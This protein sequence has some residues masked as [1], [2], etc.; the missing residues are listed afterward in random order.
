MCKQEPLTMRIKDCIIIIIII[1][2]S[3]VVY[4]YI[5]PQVSD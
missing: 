1:S 4:Y 3:F 2:S 5:F